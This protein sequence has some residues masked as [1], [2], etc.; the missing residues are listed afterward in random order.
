MN[1]L[2]EMPFNLMTE[3]TRDGERMQRALDI[4][5]KRSEQNKKAQRELFTTTE[6]R[7]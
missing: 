2:I 3:S 5:R 4:K 7:G 1:T 6:G